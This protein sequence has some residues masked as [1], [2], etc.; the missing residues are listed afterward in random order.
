MSA[1]VPGPVATTTSALP[2]PFTSAAATETPPVKDEANGAS[3]S[4]SVLVAPLNDVDLRLDSR[5]G[6]GDHVGLA[7]AV[8]VAGR[9][10]DAAV[11]AAPN[12]V[13]VSSRLVRG[14]A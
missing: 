12:G 13:S 10:R 2:S 4:S 7:V 11:E 14:S 5:A 8:H 3:V 1:A 6:A 9:D